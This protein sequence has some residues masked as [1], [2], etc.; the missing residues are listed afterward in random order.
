M[1]IGKRIQN[2]IGPQ[3]QAP[4]RNPKRLRKREAKRIRRGLARARLSSRSAGSFKGAGRC[5]SAARFTAPQCAELLHAPAPRSTSHRL[6]PR[7]SHGRLRRRHACA[8]ATNLSRRQSRFLMYRPRRAAA[9]NLTLEPWPDVIQTSA[10]R[11][12]D[13]CQT[14]ARRARRIPDAF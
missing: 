1:L 10:R 7:A 6:R 9:S 4:S 14:L 12:P 2:I 11:L 3:G 13:V 5:A 8:A